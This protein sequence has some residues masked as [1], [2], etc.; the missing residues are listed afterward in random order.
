[1]TKI[2]RFFLIGASLFF[3]ASTLSCYYDDGPAISFRSTKSRIANTWKFDYVERLGLDVTSEYVDAFL[4]LS[5]DGSLVF[6]Y[7]A[8]S[9]ATGNWSLSF[10]RKVLSFIYNDGASSYEENFVIWRL[11]E[12]EMWIQKE[13]GDNLRYE[14][15]SRD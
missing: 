11:K 15:K 8:D 13:G 2:T 6:Q 10:D 1:M 9:T 12:D 5:K 7:D 3:L 14:L 4:Q